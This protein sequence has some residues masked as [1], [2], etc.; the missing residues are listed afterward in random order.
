MTFAGSLA[1]FFSKVVSFVLEEPTGLTLE[2]HAS[3]ILEELGAGLLGVG[4]DRL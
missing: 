4:K 3:L 1:V 2:E